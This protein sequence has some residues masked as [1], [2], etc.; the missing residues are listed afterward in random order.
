MRAE[1]SKRS[2]R[3][4]SAVRQGGMGGT[5]EVVQLHDLVVHGVVAVDG[6]L[7]LRLLLGSGGL[8]VGCHGAGYLFSD[9]RDVEKRLE[10]DR[11]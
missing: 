10:K 6:E 8:G 5:Y 4:K 9:T 3:R 11:L 2:S 7:H 1:K